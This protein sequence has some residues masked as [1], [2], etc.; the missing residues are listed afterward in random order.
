[1]LTFS[2]QILQNVQLI[3]QSNVDLSEGIILSIQSF[4]SLVVA[5]GK[6]VSRAWNKHEIGEMHE[7][8][9]RLN[10]PDAVVKDTKAKT[11][12]DNVFI[13]TVASNVVWN[14]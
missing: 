4:N 8:K 13:S 12:I 10:E 1:M 7:K 5:I 3:Y 9:S 11:N 6:C 2:S 14:I